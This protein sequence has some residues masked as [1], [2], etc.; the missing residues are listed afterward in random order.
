MNNTKRN[1]ERSLLDHFF[2]AFSPVVTLRPRDE[3][4][5]D[6]EVQREL[7][8][9]A[10][11]EV[12]AKKSM[13]TAR[14]AFGALAA[15]AVAKAQV[16]GLGTL[17]IAGVLLA[18]GYRLAVAAVRLRTGTSPMAWSPAVAGVMS[19]DSYSA[20]VSDAAEGVG[21]A[22]NAAIFS[23][24]FAGVAALVVFK[25]GSISLLDAVGY[26]IVGWFGF[27]I[28]RLFNPQLALALALTR[29]FSVLDLRARDAWSRNSEHPAL[30]SSLLAT[31]RDKAPGVA[32]KVAGSERGTTIVK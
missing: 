5:R 18:Y 8:D 26:L 10:R 13:A 7:H 12:A 15:L 32:E 23:L 22:M 1:F 11:R 14:I 4:L 6:V 30:R 9:V 16:G 2:D 21:L 28:F 31:M 24:L 3:V 19:S 27:R 29:S 20:V 17:L 25:S